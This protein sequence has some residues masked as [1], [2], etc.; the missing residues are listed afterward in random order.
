MTELA[1]S[2]RLDDRE[3]AVTT[4][5]DAFVQ[6]DRTGMLTAFVVWGQTPWPPATPEEAEALATAFSDVL[7]TSHFEAFLTLINSPSH[8]S[9]LKLLRLAGAPAGLDAA[10][11]ALK[12]DGG[13]VDE[14]GKESELE[15]LKTPGESP[16]EITP[17]PPSEQEASPAIKTPLFR[18]D[19]LLV[20]GTPVTITGERPTSD[21]RSH[22]AGGN[23]AGGASPGNYGGNTDLDELNHLGMYVAL[24]FE[25]N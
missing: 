20:S 12:D 6:V 14:L 5:R 13:A 15:L 18:P 21:K 10:R 19:E 9:R 16:D 25:R 23:G 11:D 7:E 24:A 3:L 2:S 22:G 1:V 17:E 4:S 8:E